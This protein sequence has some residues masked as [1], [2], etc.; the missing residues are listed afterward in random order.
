MGDDVDDGSGDDA[1]VG[2]VE[3]AWFRIL[4]SRE[5]NLAVELNLVTRGAAAAAAIVA[6]ASAAVIV[7]GAVG[8]VGA[9]VAAVS[10]AVVVVVAPAPA[11][12]PAPA[13]APAP[14]TGRTAAAAALIGGVAW[15][16]SV[17]MSANPTRRGDGERERDSTPR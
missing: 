10:A 14:A 5:A 7:I 1:A 17:G 2:D 3:S 12:T 4:S 9:V 15:R 13:P 16:G 8:A 6:T 11:P